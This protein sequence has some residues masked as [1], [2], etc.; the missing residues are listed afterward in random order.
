MNFKAVVLDFDGTVTSKGE[1]Q[2]RQEMA[3]MLV[4]VAA[5]MP[6]AFCTG[7]QF[8]SFETHALGILLEEMPESE[9]E[10]FL[11]NCF[12]FA[13]NG[14]IGYFYNEKQA[15][16][17]EFYKIKW[18]SEVLNKTKLMREIGSRVD[19]FGKVLD[20]HE[21]VLVVQAI[22]EGKGYMHSDIRKVYEHS[23]KIYRVC[24]EVLGEMLPD[25]EEHFHVG[26]SGIGVLVGPAEGDKDTATRKFADYLVEKRGIEIGEMAREILCIG[27][28]PLLSGNDYYFLN[29]RFGS[30]YTVGDWDE[31]C[32]YPLPVLD[33]AGK[34]VLNDQGTL[35]LLEK[36]L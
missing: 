20:K 18:P 24:L 13:E 34:R 31:K 16:F 23:D 4:C 17:E 3:D 7:R 14:A 5:K 32:E 10:K 27:D 33:N 30:A 26:N 1:V 29:G 12:L 28:R 36:L 22:V 8:S 19:N 25:Y 2:P 21:V 15:K 35:V 6:I 11:R 9:H